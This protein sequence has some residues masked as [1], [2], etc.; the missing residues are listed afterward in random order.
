MLACLKQCSVSWIENWLNV[1]TQRVVISDTKSSWRPTTSG[2]SQGSILGPM[3]SHIF[4]YDLGDEAEC[5]LS[6][7]ADHTKLGTVADTPENHAASDQSPVKIN[8]PQKSASNY[9]K[10]RAVYCLL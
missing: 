3:L 5:T 2:V 7:F 1:W 9:C 4:I 10:T 8:P 6:T